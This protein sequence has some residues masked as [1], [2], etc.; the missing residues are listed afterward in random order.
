[1]AISNSYSTLDTQLIE[2]VSI[3]DR[4]P[5]TKVIEIQF[6]VFS[7]PHYCVTNLIYYSFF[8]IS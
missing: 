2:Y 6:C 3:R 4:L 8:L 5:H 1:M 7:V